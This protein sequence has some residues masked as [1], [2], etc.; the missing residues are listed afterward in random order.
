MAAA[1][2]DMEWLPDLVE[3]E[4][5]DDDL[6]DLASPET[7]EQPPSPPS[8]ADAWLSK[9][10]GKAFFPV[11]GPVSSTPKFQGGRPGWVFKLGRRGW[12]ITSTPT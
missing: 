10:R 3:A 8:S 12:A 2:G 11:S 6:E 7:K 5:M 1:P 4:F 9:H